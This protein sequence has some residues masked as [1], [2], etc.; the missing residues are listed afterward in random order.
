MWF[1]SLTKPC[2]SRIIVLTVSSEQTISMH[3]LN[4]LKTETQDCSH[5]FFK[6][7]NQTLL[8]AIGACRYVARQWLVNALERI[9][10][11]IYYDWTNDAHVIPGTAYD[12]TQV[13]ERYYI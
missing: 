7:W 3:E 5:S 1:R 10:I 11:S 9:P 2:T 8:L 13:R 12:R 4:Q 6:T